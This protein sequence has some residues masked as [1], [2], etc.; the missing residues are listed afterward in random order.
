MGRNK[1][2][3]TQL[4]CFGQCP[5]N[6]VKQKTFPSLQAAF[7][8][9]LRAAG[10]V[11]QKKQFIRRNKRMVTQLDCFGKSPRNDVKQMQ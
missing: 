5:C 8:P 2:M 1:R 6:D 11:I 4:D 7:T 3:V 10:E 9:S